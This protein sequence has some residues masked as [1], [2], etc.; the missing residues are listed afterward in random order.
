MFE[1]IPDCDVRTCQDLARD[2]A[3]SRNI[4]FGKHKSNYRLGDQND[5][6]VIKTP[7][8]ITLRGKHQLRAAIQMVALGALII[9]YIIFNLYSSMT[10]L[11]PSPGDGSD[12][13]YLEEGNEDCDTVKVANTWWMVMFYI[14]GILYSFLALAI[15][16]DEFF[17][18]A[19]EELSGPHRMNLSMDVAGKLKTKATHNSVNLNRTRNL[20]L[21]RVRQFLTHRFRTLLRF[22]YCTQENSY[23]LT[24]PL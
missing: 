9:I 24:A 10:G 2:N 5:V 7:I 20:S 19:L 18:P 22:L 17:V 11:S 12:F 13:R 21:C 16:C 3:N 4:E 23:F 8:G 15:V 6:L 1:T 14:I